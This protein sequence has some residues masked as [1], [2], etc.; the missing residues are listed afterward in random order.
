MPDSG[1]RD[2]GFEPDWRHFSLSLSKALYPPVSS[3][4]TQER[5]SDMADNLLTRTL[6]F[7]TNKLVGLVEYKHAIISADL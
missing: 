7:K 3:S 1:T 4:L 2:Y 6:R 5:R